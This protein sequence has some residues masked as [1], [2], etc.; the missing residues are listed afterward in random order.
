MFVIIKYIMG[1]AVT[2][3]RRH[4]GP[5]WL[6]SAQNYHILNRPISTNYAESSFFKT[7]ITDIMK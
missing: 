4:F 1:G 5:L 3:F 6:F 2:S 7:Q